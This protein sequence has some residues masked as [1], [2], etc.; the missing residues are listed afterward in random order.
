M[1]PDGIEPSDRLSLIGLESVHPLWP[2]QPVAPVSYYQINDCF[3][4]KNKNR[5]SCKNDQIPYF[6]DKVCDG[7]FY[8]G[9]S[10]QKTF[11]SPAALA[12]VEPAIA[13]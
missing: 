13:I 1:E 3:R 10:Y 9:N 8:S 4:N 11:Q 7:L 6:Y 5:D 12:G 2:L